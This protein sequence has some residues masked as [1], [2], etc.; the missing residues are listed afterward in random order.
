MTTVGYGDY[1]PRSQMGR[2]IGVIAC[3]IGMILLSLVVVSLGVI[4]KFTTEENKAY[5][6]LKYQIA[7]EDVEYRAAN[8][9]KI[10]IY[11]NRLNKIKRD[12]SL[13]S[14]RFLCFNSLKKEIYYFRHNTIQANSY[15][16][17]LDDMLKK[18]ETKISEDIT[19]LNSNIQKFYNIDKDI[20]SIEKEMNKQEKRL[21][22]ILHM[23]SCLHNYLIN[24]NN[25]IFKNS[26]N[27][28]NSMSSSKSIELR[29]S[30]SSKSVNSSILN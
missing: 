27:K 13:A 12:K 8:I 14:E 15:T 20:E 11:L 28:T 24:V 19:Q 16:F 10:I 6:K 23:Q 3:L 21:E 5:L 2:L 26:T 18:A 9:I 1:Y 22:R 25:P 29:S 17:N 4:T 7:H 30:N